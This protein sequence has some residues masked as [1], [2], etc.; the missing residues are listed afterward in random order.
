[1]RLYA[2]IY[3]GSYEI[4]LKAYQVTKEKKLKEIDCLRTPIDIAQD[5]IAS[6]EVRS[7]TTDRLVA[8]LTDLKRTSEMYKIKDVDIFAGSSF[9]AAKN[10]LFVL[11]QIRMRTGLTVTSLS[12]SEH[13]FISYRA[14]ASQ[15]GFDALVAESAAIVDV[16]GASL[17]ITLFHHGKVKTTQHIMLG[18]VTMSENMKRLSYMTNHKEQIAQMMY[19]E[20]DAFVTMHMADYD[21]KYLMILGDH[22][23][24]FIRPAVNDA[25][26]VPIKRERFIELLNEA[27]KKTP[28]N[29]VRDFEILG[30]HAELIEPFIMLH[31]AIAEKLSPKYVYIPGV[32]ANDG[33]AYHFFAGGRA[34]DVAHDFEND[35]LTAA[36]S[37]AK[38]YG[39]YQPHLKA[40]DR[41]SLQI[42]DTTK[43]Y[44]GLSKRERLLMRLVAILHDCGKYISISDASTCSYTIIMSS[45]I[46][47]LSH[48]EREMVA[49][50]VSMNRGALLDYEELADRFSVEEYMIIVKLLAILKVANALDRSH[51]QKFRNIKMSVRGESLA[52]TIEARDSIA[53]E[54]G[55]FEEKADFFEEVFSIRPVLKELRV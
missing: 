37:I 30:E 1:M 18:T 44:H 40:L 23:S 43:K 2:S 13:R 48:K 8:I 5:I 3:I 39:S 7:Q 15:E 54:K 42:F 21:L 47:G 25:P 29:L 49:T 12:N 26:D 27:R 41:I 33:M 16:G 31:Y 6:G 14:M 36:W 55:L 24:S 38:R 52:I 46:L 45:E 51:K 4:I 53:L 17:Q 34:L 28:E 35:I 50:V 11:E 9:A 10:R 19:K 22:A 32:S 20:L